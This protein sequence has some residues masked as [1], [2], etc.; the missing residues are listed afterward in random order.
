MKGPKRTSIK[1]EADYL[2]IAEM[3]KNGHSQI[4]IARELGLSQGQVSLDIAEV[5]RRWRAESVEF[6]DDAKQ[7][8][9]RKIDN[10]EMTYWESWERSLKDAVKRSGQSG[11]P[12]FLSGVMSCID[13][14]CK[15][16]GLDAPTESKVTG[17]IEHDYRSELLRKLADLGK[18]GRT[19]FGETGSESTTGGASADSELAS[20]D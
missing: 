10:L 3:Y 7:E 4:A 12:A 2:R 17:K 14:R 15:L 20:S 6:I 19:V 18:P 5:K 8:E 16:L 13:R 11:N 9:L 1:R